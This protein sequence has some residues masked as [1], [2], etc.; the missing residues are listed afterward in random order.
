[1]CPFKSYLSYSPQRALHAIICNRIIIF[2]LSRQTNPEPGLTNAS[3]WTLEKDVLSTVLDTYMIE[4]EACLGDVHEE[5]YGDD[6]P[7]CS[8]RRSYQVSH[9]EPWRPLT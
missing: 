6:L 5:D 1:M 3:G 7:V 8:R 9:G 4:E 2:I